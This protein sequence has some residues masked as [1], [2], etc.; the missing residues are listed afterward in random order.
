M[1]ILNLNNCRLLDK[2]PEQLV[3]FTTPDGEPAV[4][5]TFSKFYYKPNKKEGERDNVFFAE[6]VAY[7]KGL[8]NSINHT[9]KNGRCN[10]VFKLTNNYVDYKVEHINVM[11]TTIKFQLIS[12]DVIDLKTQKICKMKCA[13]NDCTNIE[14]IP[15]EKETENENKE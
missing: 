6:F 2:H 12:I 10:V 11:Y 5:G 1:V 13:C 9:R 8:V 7:G 4:R 14:L 15:N 3:Y